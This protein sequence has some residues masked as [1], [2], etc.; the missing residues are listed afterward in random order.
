[1]TATLVLNADLGNYSCRLGSR[2]TALERELLLHVWEQWPGAAPRR[3]PTS[4]EVT[5][6]RNQGL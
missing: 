6:G 4:I 1:M 2:P 5:A 3:P